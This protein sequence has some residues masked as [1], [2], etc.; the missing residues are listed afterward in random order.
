MP[1]CVHMVRE[2]DEP[3]RGDLVGAL[4]GVARVTFGPQ[5]PEDTTVLIEGQLKEEHLA[6]APLVEHVIVPFAGIQPGT[7]EVL[8][9]RPAIKAHNLHHNA[10]MTAEM[11]MALLLA[12]TRRVVRLHNEFA[13]D[14]W[15]PRFF[16]RDAL[17]LFGKTVVIVGFGEIGK[18]VGAVCR[19][20]RMEVVGVR[21]QPD[22]ESH[23]IDELH[24]L[25]PRADVLMLT[26]PGTPHTEGLIGSEEIA[27]LPP[28]AVVVN[29]GRGKVIDE[30]ALFEALR[31]GRIDSAG[32]DVWWVYPTS[33]EE[34]ASP[35][36]YPFAS[37]SNVV[38]TPH[39]GGATRDA[40][41]ARMADLARL[42]KAI[43]AGEHSAN[44]VLIDR[45]Y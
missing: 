7:R 28:H 37:L 44:R 6:G 8:Q 22:R 41:S 36:N 39:V 43:A 13:H 23:G 19:A 12:C 2:P 27:L 3:F 18:R 4:D 40:E 31:D 32:L 17:S 1:L 14:N 21:T 5:V 15:E 38:M 34:R 11:A 20:L 45:G 16:S 9:K 35:S 42:V 33:P 10:A 26:P 29:V 30:K 25:L 24:E